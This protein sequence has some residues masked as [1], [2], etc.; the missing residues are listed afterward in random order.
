MKDCTFQPNVNR[1]MPQEEG[2]EE[3][4]ADMR[5]PKDAVEKKSLQTRGR[6]T[7]YANKGKSLEP[8][9]SET[10]VAVAG[11]GRK[12][13]KVK[14]VQTTK[15]GLKSQDAQFEKQTPVSAATR[16]RQK[17]EA[18]DDQDENGF[19]QYDEYGEPQY[20]GEDFEP[21]NSRWESSASPYQSGEDSLVISSPEPSPQRRVN[22]YKDSR[23]LEELDMD[24]DEWMSRVESSW[25]EQSMNAS[26]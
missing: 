16:R 12:K 9:G 14:L 24:P 19:A 18:D 11:A 20:G 7:G 5:R 3:K 22:S 17:Y 10:G 13:P 21:G 6:T 8:R 26:Q 25:Q 1:G 2:E 15:I 4:E 23:M